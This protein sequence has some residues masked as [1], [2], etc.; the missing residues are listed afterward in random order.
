[1]VQLKGIAASKVDPR[2]KELE[3]EV[4]APLQGERLGD[5]LIVLFNAI[6]KIL[7]DG[8][9]SL[10]VF[11]TNMTVLTATW[12]ANARERYQKKNN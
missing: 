2:L 10:D 11:E 1:M 8:S 12:S 6:N 7:L 9:D 3:V 5:C 4:M